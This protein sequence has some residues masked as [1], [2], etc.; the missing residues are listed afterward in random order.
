VPASFNAGA[1]V[2]NTLTYDY[3]QAGRL[4]IVKGAYG[5]AAPVTL[6]SSTA[7][8]ERGQVTQITQ[9]N[10]TLAYYVYTPERGFLTRV[11]AFPLSGQGL[12]VSYYRDLKGRIV[13][14]DSTVNSEDWQYSYDALGRLSFA[15]N[16]GD[17][18]QDR[19]YNYDLADNLIFNTAI[20]CGA[21]PQ[22]IVYPVAG[23]PRPHAP[24]TICGSAVTYDANGNTLSYDADGP[25]PEPVKS[26][27]Y[28]AENRPLTVT[29]SGLTSTYAYDPE[30]ERA[31]KVT[32]A[33]ASLSTTTYLGNDAEVLVDQANTGPGLMTA[34]L[35]PDTMREGSVTKWLHKD[36]LASNR[37]VTGQTGAVLNRTAYTPTGQPLTPPTQ[38]RAWI[39][40]RYD[41]ETGL[42]YLHARYYDP[43]RGQFLTPDTW[44]PELPGVDFNRYAYAGNDPINASD[45]NGHAGGWVGGI[46]N[47]GSSFLDYEINGVRIGDV[48]DITSDSMPVV[49]H[50]KE[51]LQHPPNTMDFWGEA[52][53]AV[54]DAA[55]LAGAK[56]GRASVTAPRIRWVD[57]PASIDSGIQ[58]YQDGA[59]GARYSTATRRPSVP[60]LEYQT[61][62]GKAKLA[63]FDGIDGKVL[64]DRK[65]DVVFTDK[66]RNQAINQAAALRQNGLTGRWELPTKAAAN[67]AQKLLNSLGIKNIRVEVEKPKNHDRRT[68]P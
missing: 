48:L 62:D 6:T 17:N 63:K 4:N 42:Q 23:Q 9:G 10:G 51:A 35:T 5:A 25:G 8:N 16:L 32:G 58:A 18:A 59:T 49:G 3:D 60:A 43:L 47:T 14:A 55:M 64:I 31:S 61:K 1:Q 21:W 19:W 46:N 24:L 33:G 11:A 12:D 44:N 30:G 22:N 34:Y 67:R 56:A 13:V 68:N 15:D 45:P 65:R 37:L 28:D 54:G 57:E 39:N 38:S 41:V 20:S 7:Y 66:S 2:S 53:W 52:G 36:H 27:T 26:F 50:A 29:K 40:E